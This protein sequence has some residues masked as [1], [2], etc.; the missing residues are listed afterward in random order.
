MLKVLQAGRFFAA[1]AVVF[2]HAK[3]SISFFVEDLPDVVVSVLSFG[4]LGVDFFFV[5]SGF[6][7]HYTMADSK[8]TAGEFAYNRLTRVFVPYW[9]IGLC[10][11]IAY[12]VVPHLSAAVDYSWSWISTITLF[13]TEH[14]PALAVAWTLQHELVFY[15]TYAALHFKNRVFAGLSLWVFLI[16][17]SHFFGDADLPILR[18]MLSSI[19]L[20]FV[21]GVLA[22]AV[23]LRKFP[24]NA[25]VVVSISATL[26]IA[27]T[28]RGAEHSDSIL[29]GL[30]IAVLLPLLCR[31]EKEGKIRVANILVE[32]GNVSYAIYLTHNPLIALT[33]RA[34]GFFQVNWAIALFLSALISVIAGTAYYLLWERPVM[35]LLKSRFFL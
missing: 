23:I 4:Y 34:F 28:V 19:N 27:F 9:P 20:E 18:L 12:T 15:L 29:V 14:D 32:G 17:A 24:F 3:T 10:L 5:L 30:A 1:M 2:V 21:A 6:I 7:I 22:A 26:L 8:R 16:A 13:P 35:R 31:A 11:A 25:M 33:S